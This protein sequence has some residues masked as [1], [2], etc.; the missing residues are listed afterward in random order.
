[1][2]DECTDL[3]TILG[4]SPQATQDQI[5]RAYRGL[6]R[7]HHP[8]T[9]DLT[10]IAQAAASDAV[11]QHVLAAYAVLGDPARRATYDRT[12]A[13]RQQDPPH[14]PQDN[15]RRMTR[16]ANPPPIQVGPVRWHR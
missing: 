11:L 16:R 6:L 7:Q 2:T 9:R 5:T 3:Y 13:I 1:M 15:H 12:S 10:V 8:D 14:Q 4:L